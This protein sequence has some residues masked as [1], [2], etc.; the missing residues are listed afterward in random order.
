MG[1][2]NLVAD[3]DRTDD[4]EY[5]Q[6]ITRIE[7]LSAA[8]PAGDWYPGTFLSQHLHRA[9]LATQDETLVAL[10]P[11]SR[12]AE[13]VIDGGESDVSHLLAEM[14]RVAGIFAAREE[15]RVNHF[16]QQ[17]LSKSVGAPL[18]MLGRQLYQRR[19]VRDT[20]GEVRESGVVS[21]A[22]SRNLTAEMFVVELREEEL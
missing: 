4:F 15:P 13:V 1:R 5:P 19:L 12:S 20:P 2:A 11:R 21:D 18:E 17:R 7:A 6:S 9:V 10:T 14:R 3:V 8:S 16:V 22:M